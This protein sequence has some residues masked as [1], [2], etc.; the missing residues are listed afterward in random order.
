MQKF[1]LGQE[2]LLRSPMLFG[3]GEA[4]A[5]EC[6]LSVLIITFP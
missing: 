6:P 1:L 4:R 2:M 5:H 3:S